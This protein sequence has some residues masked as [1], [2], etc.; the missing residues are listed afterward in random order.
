MRRALEG[1]RVECEVARPGR[2]LECTFAP[3][4]DEAENRVVGVTGVAIDVTE[5]R[6]TEAAL[7]NLEEQNRL[8]I[9]NA[10]DA[11]IAYD[12]SGRFTFVNKRF[13]QLTGYCAQDALQMSIKDLR[14]EERRVGKECRS[15]WSPYH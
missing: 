10:N 7:R 13:E 9:D 4:F 3:M 11:V 12:M 15:R 1:E 5:R 14:S 6:R 8:L 2:V